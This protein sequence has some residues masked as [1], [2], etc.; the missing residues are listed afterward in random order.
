MVVVFHDAQSKA[1]GE[2]AMQKNFVEYG[3]RLEKM[4]SDIKKD[5][6]EMPKVAAAA[7]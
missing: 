2:D 7:V 5:L 6:K 4:I 3:Q 1:A